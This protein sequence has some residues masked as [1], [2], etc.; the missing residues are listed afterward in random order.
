MTETRLHSQ[1]ACALGPWIAVC[2]RYAGSVKCVL[3]MLDKPE[4]PTTTFSLP[5]GTFLDHAGYSP[6]IPSI[7][8]ISSS[9]IVTN[10]ICL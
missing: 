2:I 9:I 8:V 7:T 3:I 1:G 6:L 10:I 5:D 4:F